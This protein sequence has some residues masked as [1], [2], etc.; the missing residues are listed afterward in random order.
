MSAADDIDLVTDRPGPARVRAR[1]LSV[2]RLSQRDLLAGAELYPEQPGIDYERP[3]TYGDCVRAGLG[4]STPCP[5]VSCSRHLALDVNPHTGSIKHNFPD[6]DVDEMTET[7]SL[8]VAD[9]GGLTLE[10]TGEVLNLTRERVRQLEGRALRMA[11]ADLAGL[12]PADLSAHDDAWSTV[13]D[14]ADREVDVRS[15]EAWR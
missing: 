4:S 12:D 9:R 11:K 6:L 10:E 2:S 5:F 1:T 14:P 3:R 13:A 8:A 7:C 15:T